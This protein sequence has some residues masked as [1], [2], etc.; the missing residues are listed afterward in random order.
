MI[1]ETLTQALHTDDAQQAAALIKDDFE[2]LN[3]TDLFDD[4]ESIA[5]L[6]DEQADDGFDVVDQNYED[7]DLDTADQKYYYVSQN[8][9]DEIQIAPVDQSIFATIKEAL[10][11]A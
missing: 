3:S 7:V 4:I 2:V 10:A 1:K 11:N 8:G 9:I 5:E 6:K